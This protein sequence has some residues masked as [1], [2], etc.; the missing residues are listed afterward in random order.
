MVQLTIAHPTS[1]TSSNLQE[2]L[3][4][5][6]N[7]SLFHPN[8]DFPITHTPFHG[9]FPLKTLV[10]HPPLHVSRQLWSPIFVKL[11]TSNPSPPRFRFLSIT[12]NYHLRHNSPDT[13]VTFH[14]HI[15][16]SNAVT[17]FQTNPY[18]QQYHFEVH[19]GTAQQQEHID[20]SV[21]FL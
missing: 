10:S 7:G 6:L 3:F 13:Y 20:I 8:V 9:L 2:N 4:Y 15:W 16:Y 12:Y 21:R 5:D 18:P 17:T 1:V 19:S 14:F 11:F